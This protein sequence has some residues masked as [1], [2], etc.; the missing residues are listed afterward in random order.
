MVVFICRSWEV[1]PDW[2]ERP[3]SREVRQSGARRVKSHRQVQSVGAARIPPLSS[4][5]RVVVND[6]TRVAHASESNGRRNLSRHAG[7]RRRSPAAGWEHGPVRVRDWGRRP[8]RE[9]GSPR[10]SSGARPRGR[11]R[12]R[13]AH[14][15]RETAT[16][17]AQIR[18]QPGRREAS[19]ER[20]SFDWAWFT[21]GEV[22]GG[23]TVRDPARRRSRAPLRTND[24]LHRDSGASGRD[25]THVYD[26][27][28]P[29]TS[30]PRGRS[31]VRCVSV[32]RTNNRPIQRAVRVAPDAD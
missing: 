22:N 23:P 32:V 27:G 16:R 8:S 9:R 18:P 2:V 20:Q 10:R 19:R 3:G 7:S 4:N 21:Y 25:P 29:S 1:G 6:E 31:W 14:R 12:G 26:A 30:S 13:R 24:L 28:R 17:R 11:M 15:R 5:A